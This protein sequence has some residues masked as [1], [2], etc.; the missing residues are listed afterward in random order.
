MKTLDI[1]LIFFIPQ[2]LRH[3]Q[4]QPSIDSKWEV[5]WATATEGGVGK[6]GTSV[7][8]LSKTGYIL[9]S[10]FRRESKRFLLCLLFFSL[11]QQGKK[12]FQWLDKAIPL[13]WLQSCTMYLMLMSRSGPVTGMKDQ[14]GLVIPMVQEALRNSARILTGKENRKRCPTQPVMLLCCVGSTQESDP[15]PSSVSGLSPPQRQE[16]PPRVCLFNFS[17]FLASSV[18]LQ[19]PPP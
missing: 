4:K 14:D 9:L 3:I 5:Q 13:I 7:L 1:S 19:L 15:P 11:K 6:N 12:F 8:R 16:A 18:P 17:S 2:D 10:L